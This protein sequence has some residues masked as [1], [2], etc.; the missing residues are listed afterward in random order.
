VP[1]G[2]LAGAGCF[3][4]DSCGYALAMQ[5]LDEV[6]SCPHCGGRDF[7]RSSM[8]GELALAEPTGD[9]PD[10]PEWLGEAR[11]ALV[12][13]GIYVAYEDDER[14]RVIAL[15]EGWTRVGRSLSAHIRFDDP[16]VS[17]RHGSRV[18]M[19][20]LRDGDQVAIGRFQ[21]HFISLR[22]RAQ[23]PANRPVGAA[24]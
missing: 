14:I 3:R 6:P 17:R 18:D 21:L 11:E 24:A 5:E 4:C 10:E 8:F 1:A 9:V 20:E 19:R 22:H 13:S 23:R 12:A 15:Q 16:T 2:T 7:R